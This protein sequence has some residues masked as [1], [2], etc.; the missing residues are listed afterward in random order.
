MGFDG[1][2]NAGR[3]KGAEVCYNPISKA[4]KRLA[5]CVNT[6]IVK[7][8][9]QNS[10]GLKP[11]ND[12]GMLNYTSMPCFLVECGFIDNRDDLPLITDK[13]AQERMGNAI[14]K[15][16]CDYLGVRWVSYKAIAKKDC[17]LFA[18]PS[19]KSKMAGSA[20]LGNIMKIYRISAGGSWGYNGKGWI[21][22]KHTRKLK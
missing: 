22:L 18:E 13:K 2:I 1:H 10:R 14:A 15:G 6:A 16:I 19:S 20:K 3:G 8:T 7:H 12:L 4:S 17:K 11:R 9:D 21:K 5:L